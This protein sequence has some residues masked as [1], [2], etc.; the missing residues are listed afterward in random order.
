[1]S[2]NF[3]QHGSQIVTMSEEELEVEMKYLCH[4]LDQIFQSRMKGRFCGYI[5]CRVSE[6]YKVSVP[7]ISGNLCC[8]YSSLRNHSG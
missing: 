6:D 7:V 2:Q 8:Y 5:K 1:M 3:S 4:S